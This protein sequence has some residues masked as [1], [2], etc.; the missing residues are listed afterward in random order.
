MYIYLGRHLRKNVFIVCVVYFNL[1]EILR[2]TGSDSEVRRRGLQKSSKK[3]CLQKLHIKMQLIYFPPPFR[4][5]Q[6]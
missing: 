2:V 1:S 3:L 6:P 4:Y 5:R